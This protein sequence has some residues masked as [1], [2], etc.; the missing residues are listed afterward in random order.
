MSRFFV[1]PEA[2]KGNSIFIGAKEAHHIL[3]VMRLKK[4]DGVITFDGTGKEYT[5]VIKDISRNSL[6]VE[7]TGTRKLSVTE[8][9]QITLIQALPKK[10]KMDYI[11]EKSTELGVHSI[12]PAITGRTIPDWDEPKKRSQA[13][14]WK[15]IAREAAKQCGRAD[16]PVISAISK[17][18]DAIGNFNDF[19]MRLIAVLSEK[20][21]PVKEAIA[22]FKSGKIVAAIG[23]EGD[24]TADESSFAGKCGFKAISLGP[25]VLKSDTAGLALL[26]ILNYELSPR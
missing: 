14:R 5:G 1:P 11:V 22:G 24:F 2:V 17:F 16:I 25:R 18:T 23:P 19:D 12:V 20:T 4:S 7:I 3:D 15:K 10:E 8:A 13:E 6:T 26:S 21:V 9:L